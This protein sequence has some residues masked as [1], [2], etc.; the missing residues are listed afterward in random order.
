M[1]ALQILMAE[2]RLQFLKKKQFY[3][4]FFLKK[5]YDRELVLYVDNKI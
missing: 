1:Q 3:S 5:F 2:L 4:Q